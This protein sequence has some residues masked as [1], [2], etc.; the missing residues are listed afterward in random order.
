MDLLLKELS[1][2]TG[3]KIVKGDIR[4]RKG[5]IAEIGG[6]LAASK[7]EHSITFNNHFI[8]PGLINAHDHLEMN[9]YPRLGNPPYNSYIDW[10]ND[11]YKPKES[12][13]KEIEKVPIKDRLLWG[14]LKNLVSGV[15]TVVHHNPW[16][17]FMSSKEFPVRVLKK[18]AWAHSV[19]FGKNILRSFPKNPAT[20]FI[21]HAA[22]GVDET[23]HHEVSKLSGLGL[24]KSNTVLIHGIALK[25]ETISA[26]Q[27]A[28]ASV[29]WCPASNDFLFKK[30]A[31]VDKL[32]KAVKIALGSDSTLTGSPTLLDEMRSAL[33]TG[34]ATKS[35][36]YTMVT[37][38]P[39]K[40]FS[41][42]QPAIEINKQADIFILPVHH[43]DYI[44]NLI[45][46]KSSE[47][48]LVLINGNPEYSSEPVAKELSLKKT[49]VNVNGIPK[50]FRTDVLHLKKKIQKTTGNVVENNPLWQLIG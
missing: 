39:A 22:E 46:S 40:I 34:L 15:T 36:I 28:G 38:N 29:V 11:I 49:F 48:E 18:Y 33:Q 37:L 16:N 10:G 2:Q 14:A 45:N 41:L 21:I 7:R 5:I 9:L 42:H 19:G 43:N 47:I 30:T 50:W 12:P 13:I 8:Y 24:L 31:P 6:N 3:A 35:E 26:L 25:D 27:T 20:P 1:W 23:A 17:R 4:I 44:E 32:K